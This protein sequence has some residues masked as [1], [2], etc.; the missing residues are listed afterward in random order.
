MEETKTECNDTAIGPVEKWRLIL[1]TL[2]ANLRCAADSEDSPI[3]LKNQVAAERWWKEDVSWVFDK[4][5]K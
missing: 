1:S 5:C 2:Q 4:G 3:F